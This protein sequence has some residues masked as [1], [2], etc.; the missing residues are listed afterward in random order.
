MDKYPE[1]T[2]NV[3]SMEQYSISADD[4]VLFSVI[5]EQGSLVRAADHL[6]MPKATVSRRLAM[7]ESGLGQ[8]LLVRTTRRLS[9]TGFGQEFLEH[10]RRVA[11]EASAAMDFA[12]SSEAKPR[13]T[14]RVSMPG[15]YALLV[16]LSRAISTFTEQ[17]PEIFL[18]LDFSSRRVDLLGEHYDLAIRMGKLEESSTLV[19][20]KIWA[21]RSGLYASPI[22]L[23]LHFLPSRPE[24]LLLCET[25]CMSSALGKP[26]PWKLVRGKEA[27]E[28]APRGRITVNSIGMIR[29]LVLD[30]AGI[31]VLPENLAAADV[32]QGRLVRVLPE[33]EFPPVPAWAVT[34]TR[35]YLPKKTSAFLS[36]L[37]ILLRGEKDI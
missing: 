14:L 20:R 27:W 15:D 16:P 32:R 18:E 12:R 2:Y 22:H 21:L 4:L 13:G 9:L 35:R 11:E 26:L 30:G 6:G 31:G 1:I 23:G 28:G 7:L 34:P 33:W 24:D 5:A 25:I 3:P 37:E 8:K 29:D 36:H 17:Y 19:A 10:C